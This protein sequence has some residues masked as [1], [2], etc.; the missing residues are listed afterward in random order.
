MKRLRVY[1]ILFG[2][3][4]SLPLLFVGWRTYGALDRE[5]E[6]QVRFFA[7]R[8]FDDMETEM[9]ELVQREERRGVD[10]YRHTL[11]QD[12]HPVVSPL[13]HGSSDDFILGYFQ[14][15]PDGSFQTPLA[16]D[17]TRLPFPLPARYASS[18]RST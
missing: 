1:M 10:A 14:N 9:A 8:L 12:G 7:E 15:N 17:A 4:L 13:A 18:K 3:L 16:A 2:V 5:A 11:V 6:A